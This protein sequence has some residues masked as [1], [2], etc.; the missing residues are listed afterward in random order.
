[1]P[2]LDRKGWAVCLF[3]LQG[4]EHDLSCSHSWGCLANVV[5]L[6]TEVSEVEGREGA[7]VGPYSCLHYCSWVYL[8]EE[9]Q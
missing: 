7:S 5:I 1:M 2:E 4:G 6:R 3:W 9:L 8:V